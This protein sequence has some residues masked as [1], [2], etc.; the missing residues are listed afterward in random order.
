[1]PANEN[2]CFIATHCF[3]RAWIVVGFFLVAACAGVQTPL[4]PAGDQAANIAWLFWLFTGVCAAIWLAVVIVLIAAIA[5]RRW[6]PDK[7]P[8][9]PEPARERRMGQAVGV[10]TALTVVTLIVFTGLSYLTTRGFGAERANAM[11]IVLTGKQWWWQIEYKGIMPSESFVTANEL[12]VAVGR[13]VTIQ[14]VS[15]DVIHS[16]WIPNVAGK[17]DLIPGRT[18]TISFTVAKPGTYRGQCA[19]FCGLQHAHMALL[20]VADRPEDF[21]AWR[22]HELSEA[23]APARPETA[24]GLEIFLRNGCAA[25]HSLRGTPASG[26]LG[27]D[28]THVGARQTI[29]AGTLPNTRG[30]LQGWIADPQSIKPGAQMPRLELSAVDLNAVAGYLASLQ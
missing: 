1:M 21:D 5:R 28:L 16:F 17:M 3:G 20:L 22:A 9:E 23:P 30:N 14:L 27:P 19:E 15:N 6:V 8:S 12:H 4:D 7:S 18:N 25:C 24:H 13:P 29:G 10:A 11:Q 26:R 2:Q